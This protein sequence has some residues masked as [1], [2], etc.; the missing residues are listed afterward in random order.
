MA[1]SNVEQKVV[2]QADISLL[3]VPSR[4]VLALRFMV[5]LSALMSF[6]SISTDMYLPALPTI[7][8][9]LHTDMATAELSISTFLLGFSVG[10]LLWGPISDR[11]GRRAPIVAGLMLFIIG[12]AGCALV[13]NAPQFLAWRVVQA[14]GACAGP[15]LARAMIRDRHDGEHA[16][17][18]LSILMLMMAVAP[19]LGPLFGGQILRFASWRW[20]FWVLAAIGALILVALHWLPETLPAN[21]RSVQALSAT[22][23]DYVELVR[24]RRLIGFAL[25]GAFWYGACYAFIAGAPFA[26]VEFYHVPPSAFGLLFG[27]NIIGSMIL[28]FANSRLIPRFGSL[29]LLRCGAWVVAVA[30]CV[31]AIDAYFGFG[32]VA[33]LAIPFFCVMAVGGFISANSVAGALSAFPRQ[34]GTA[35]SLVGAMHYGSGVLSAAMLGVFA[36]G[37]PWPMGWIIGAGG[38]GCLLTILLQKQGGMRTSA[39]QRVKP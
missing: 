31:M 19:L 25:S 12:S 16:A 21:R 30:G 13:T 26:Y 23:R 36:D 22:L 39:V 11:M 10:Q 5:I 3:S 6:G 34:A 18:K 32:G 33:G 20:I 28:N 38:L 27:V 14:V 4:D 8:R 9:D 15:V 24:D 17:Q 35:S 29:R 7:A 37:T 2:T 1:G